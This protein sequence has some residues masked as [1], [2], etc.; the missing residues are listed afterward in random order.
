VICEIMFVSEKMT[1]FA[2]CFERNTRLIIYES[3][4]R[5]NKRAKLTQSVCA[6]CA[7]VSAV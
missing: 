3:P 1:I 4:P 2:P 5:R 7:D 6:L